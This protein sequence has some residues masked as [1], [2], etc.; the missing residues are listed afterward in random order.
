[1]MTI[2]QQN[3]L[4]RRVEAMIEHVSDN[5]RA[6][7][8]LLREALDSAVSEEKGHRR[9][10]ASFTR[11]Q[12]GYRLP[13]RQTALL[14]VGRWFFGEQ[15]ASIHALATARADYRCA[16]LARSLLSEHEF[17]EASRVLDTNGDGTPIAEWDYSRDVAV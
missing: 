17:A 3:R 5:C 2:A 4:A 12:A 10:G 9:M 1:M 11:G 13:V 14:F 16:A 7:G 15:P 6:A 8:A